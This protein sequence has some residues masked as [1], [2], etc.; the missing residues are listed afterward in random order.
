[1]LAKLAGWMGWAGKAAV[2][3]LAVVGALS[4]W[5]VSGFVNYLNGEKPHTSAAQAV[6]VVSVVPAVQKPVAV[7]AGKVDCACSSG[8]MCGG[9]KGW[10]FCT[11][12]AG[13]K[14]FKN[15]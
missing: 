8:A 12:E 6:P 9:E 3:V 13:N 7:V 1:M 11:D 15:Q 14:K 10:Y 2:V 4:I 5:L